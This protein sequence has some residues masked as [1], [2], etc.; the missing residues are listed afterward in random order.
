[1]SKDFFKETLAALESQSTFNANIISL[2]K[3]TQCEQVTHFRNIIV[4]F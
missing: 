1:M 2:P 4:T 3:Y